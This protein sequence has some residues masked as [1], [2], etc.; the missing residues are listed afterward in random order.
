MTQAT[1][2]AA[3]VVSLLSVFASFSG[4]TANGMTAP[5][6]GAA[7]LG[8]AGAGTAMAE[9]SFAIL[10]N[11]AAA[12]W[13]ESGAAYDLG[14]AVPDGGTTV[15]AVGNNSQFG[16]IDIS[17]GQYQPISGVYP[18]PAYARNWRIDDRTAIGWGVTASGMKSITANGSAALARGLPTFDANCQGSFGGGEPVPGRPDIMGLCG[19]SG[20]KLGV[21]LTQFLI[22]MHFS[23]RVHHGLSI[24]ISPVL[25]AQR[26]LIRG[27]GAFSAFSNSPQSTTDNGFDL[28][29][30]G[31][32]RLGVLWELGNGVGIGAA[33]QTRLYQSTFDRY[34]GVVIDG[35][36]DF[37][38][39]LNLGAH[40][41]FRPGHRLLIDLEHIEYSQVTPLAQ[42]VDPQRFSDECFIPRVLS[43]S[44]RPAPLA[45]CLG[46]RTGPG[47]GWRNVTVHKLGYEADLGRWRVRAGFS[48]V[49]N[50]VVAGQTLSK[51]YAPAITDQH[52]SVG[53][54]FNRRN[55]SEIQLAL[56]H[57]LKNS[58]RERNI[59]SNAQ[60]TAL[61]GN[62]VGYVIE[63]DGQDQF[64]ESSLSA[65]ELHMTF[66]WG[67]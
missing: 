8:R 37:A 25:A 15:G 57:A 31:G 27:L 50:P 49:G 33:Y 21:D 20:T 3:S 35:S 22:S 65:W 41:H 36:I 4:L 60:L 55:G 13:L 2:W 1:R 46:G 62:P 11:P 5:G 17:P 56:V 51:F 40:F 29:Y 16:L 53:L 10:R 38:P 24:G 44:E 23:R 58:S 43:R 61:N 19:N 59:F 7:Q 12:A 14:I 18:I 63:P 34:E 67:H 42:R 32:L 9:D 47:F 66:S 45:A 30:G 54:S 6:H 39:I 48:W 26:I 64:L 52:A 28:S